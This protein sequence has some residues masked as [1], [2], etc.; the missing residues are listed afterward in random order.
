MSDAKLGWEVKLK[1]LVEIDVSV[2][3]FECNHWETT[4]PIDEEVTLKILDVV[5]KFKESFP[6]RTS[7]D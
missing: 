3:C 2:C 1:A 6:I 5:T 7:L 4:Y